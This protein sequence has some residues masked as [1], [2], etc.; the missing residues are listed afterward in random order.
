MVRNEINAG[1][2]AGSRAKVYNEKGIEAYCTIGVENRD[3]KYKDFFLVLSESEV[4][5]CRKVFQKR[6]V[7]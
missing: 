6:P 4:L 2:M 5:H 7:V 1:H 3:P